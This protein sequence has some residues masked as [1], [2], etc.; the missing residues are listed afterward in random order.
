MMGRK[1]RLLAVPDPWELTIVSAILRSLPEE[2]GSEW[3]DYLVLTT[4]AAMKASRDLVMPLAYSYWPWA[5]VSNAGRLLGIPAP[6]AER[7]AAELREQ[8]DI[9]HADEVWIWR[10]AEYTNR[11]V[12]AYPGCKVVIYD[13][14]FN[15]HGPLRE[16]LAELLPRLD[17]AYL[18]WHDYLPLPDYL[19][20]L[21]LYGIPK[22][23]LLEIIRGLD[24]SFPEARTVSVEASADR[25]KVLVLGRDFAD[26]EGMSAEDGLRVHRKV[27]TFL[28]ESGYTVLWKD[29]PKSTQNVMGVL[30]GE[31]NFPDGTL[32]KFSLN[33]LIPFELIAEK[34]DVVACVSSVSNAM[35]TSEK[36]FGIPAYT[37]QHWTG[38]YT[39]QRF[40]FFGELAARHF[41]PIEAIPRATAE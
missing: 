34:L 15:N 32:V 33:H 6:D 20:R 7:N 29:H 31:S 24:E 41:Q 30:A 8:L 18:M 12:R 11:I 4:H 23:T 14:G 25:P 36:L 22:E 13:G 26:Y 21:P 40:E 27:V 10:A 39:N 17:R 9:Y 3:D 19:N 37:F 38:A 28:I 1:I 2:E 5:K 35:Y 16:P